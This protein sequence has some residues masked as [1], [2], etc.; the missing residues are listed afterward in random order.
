ML[1]ANTGAS[2]HSTAMFEVSHWWQSQNFPH[3]CIVFKISSIPVSTRFIVSSADSFFSLCS[4]N[5]LDLDVWPFLVSF[6]LCVNTI[7]ASVFLCVNET[8]VFHP[9]CENCPCLFLSACKARLLKSSKGQKHLP[10]HRGS[11]LSLCVN[12]VPKF[13]LLCLH[14]AWI[15]FAGVC[16]MWDCLRSWM[17]KGTESCSL[18]S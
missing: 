12:S 3:R 7:L 14:T 2:M 1:H 8:N 9:Q 13:C 4:A 17:F 11:K 16:V 10:R 6:S 18:P 5:I 15:L